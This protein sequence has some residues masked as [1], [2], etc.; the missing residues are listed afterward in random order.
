MLKVYL[1]NTPKKI[2]K[3]N[4][5]WF[6]ENIEKI[7]FSNPNVIRA[8]RR[9]DGAKYRGNFGVTTQF[10]PNVAISILEIS[11][12]CKTAINICQF[13]NEIFTVA[14]CGENALE[15]IFKLDDGGIYVAYQAVMPK[16]DLGK[17]LELVI[18]GNSRIITN[19]MDLRLAIKEYFRLEVDSI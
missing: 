6:Q 4:D 8:M 14:E 13:T 11:T 3:Y 7:D 19:Y 12:G 17:T 1:G 2:I 15:E 5:A 16:F 9:I 18:D 10:S